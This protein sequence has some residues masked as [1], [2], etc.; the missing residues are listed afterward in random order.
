MLTGSWYDKAY[1]HLIQDPEKDFLCPIIGYCDACQIYEKSQY[2]AHS[3]TITLA[4][5]VP[6]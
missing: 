5:F 6:L 4:I 2:G 1:E 3:F